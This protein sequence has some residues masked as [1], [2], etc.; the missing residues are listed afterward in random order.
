MLKFFCRSEE[1]RSGD[2]IVPVLFRES[3]PLGDGVPADTVPVLFQNL[4]PVYFRERGW[5]TSLLATQCHCEPLF[6]EA[7]SSYQG[8][9]YRFKEA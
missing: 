2:D 7:I 8:M 9:T 1:P 5:A 3:S 6:G 4:V